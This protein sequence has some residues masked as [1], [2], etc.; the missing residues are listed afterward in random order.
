MAD[1]R[2]WRGD[3]VGGTRVYKHARGTLAG[4]GSVIDQTLG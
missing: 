3:I 4:G 2:R 1:S